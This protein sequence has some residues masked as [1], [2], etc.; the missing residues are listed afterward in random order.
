MYPPLPSLPAPCLQIMS[1]LLCEGE[2]D[3]ASRED[4]LEKVLH[5]LCVGD[6]NKAM[7]RLVYVG[8]YMKVPGWRDR[9]GTYE[10]GR[11]ANPPPLKPWVNLPQTPNPEP[12]SL[13]PGPPSPRPLTL[14][15]CPCG[16]GP[17]PPDP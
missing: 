11:V 7:Y 16:P 4:V 1:S 14:S 9:S 2:D 17:P 5:A 3:V 6:S 15:P 8:G 12:L 10:D 13:R